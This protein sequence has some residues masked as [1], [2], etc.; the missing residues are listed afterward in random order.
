M[1]IGAPPLTRQCVIWLGIVSN[2]TEWHESLGKIGSGAKPEHGWGALCSSPAW[3]A[4]V[5]LDIMSGRGKK[6]KQ[7]V[8]GDTKYHFGMFSDSTQDIIKL[9]IHYL[10]EF[11]A[12]F[13][14]CVQR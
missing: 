12:Y 1:R 11:E 7:L 14:K 2:P 13:R 4:S 6:S 3:S 8:N 10:G 9:G 5:C